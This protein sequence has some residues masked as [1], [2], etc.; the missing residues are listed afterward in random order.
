MHF[1]VA[2]TDAL[3]KI[4]IPEDHTFIKD[5]YSV[6][7]MIIGAEDKKFRAKQKRIEQRRMKEK[8]RRQKSWDG[9]EELP[10]VKKI[11][12]IWVF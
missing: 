7:R 2:H 9:N 8:E 3:V 11:N 5:R 1:N 6:R 4:Y 12:A 10:G